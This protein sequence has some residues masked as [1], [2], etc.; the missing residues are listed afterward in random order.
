M[1]YYYF[2][3]DC[4]LFFFLRLQ[5][6]KLIFIHF[7]LTQYRQMWDFG[8]IF[9]FMNHVRQPKTVFGM[10]VFHK[11]MVL[12]MSRILNVNVHSYIMKDINYSELPNKQACSLHIFY[13]FENHFFVFKELFS[14]NSSLCISL[15]VYK[16]VLVY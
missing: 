4:L 15:L 7:M 3:Q 9:W 11:W 5:I 16:G 13:I 6:F 12:F 14:E 1:D 10:C 2:T 8:F